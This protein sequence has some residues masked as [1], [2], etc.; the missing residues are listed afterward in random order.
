LATFQEVLVFAALIMSFFLF[1]ERKNI[2]SVLFY[3]CAL[4][5][6]E[7]AILYVLFL[8]FVSVFT[9]IGK[10]H[11]LVDIKKGLKKLIPY[12][13]VSF[14][15]YLLYRYSL[16]YVTALDN[17]KMDFGF[18]KIANNALWYYLW[19]WG[20][21]SVLPDYMKSVFSMPIPAFW[22]FFSLASFRM[23]FFSFTLYVVTF[24]A[25]LLTFCAIYKKKIKRILFSFLI[26]TACFFLFLGPMLFFPHKW[27]V[28]LTVPLIFLALFQCYV[29]Y[30]YGR[31][32][33]FFQTLAILLVCLYL[34]VHYFGTQFNENSSTYLLESSITKRAQTMFSNTE[35][36]K[37]C[38]SLYFADPPAMKMGSWDGS[39]KLALTFF[40]DAFI[41]TYFPQRKNISVFYQYK[42][43]I[44]PLSSCTIQASELI[45]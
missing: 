7:T 44:I 9:Q 36:F 42:T 17:Y 25:S 1:L 23:Y 30:L 6:K 21:P 33:H 18:R 37:N 39:E 19:G 2:L 28:R 24:F 22:S 41:S 11:A 45:Q 16:T 38:T 27:M 13:I 40:G 20:F 14:L 15:F 12:L 5:S 26:A 34:V 10:A 3:I 4:L 32:N 31:A 35:R 43:P 8:V 29:I